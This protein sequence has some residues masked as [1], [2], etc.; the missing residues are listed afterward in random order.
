MKKI[1][2]PESRKQFYSKRKDSLV[3]KSNELGVVCDTYIALLMFSPTG[4]VTT[5][6]RGKSFEGI[7]INAINQP[8]ELNRQPTPNPDEEHL[9]QSLAQSK[10][11]RGMIEKIS[12]YEAHKEKLSELQKTLSEAKEKRRFYEPQVENINTVEEVDVYKEY[13]LGAMERVKRSKANQEFLKRNRNVMLS[14]VNA[15]DM[16]AACN[17]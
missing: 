8:D 1:E 9:M 17:N 14:S 5:Y 2:D 11:E 4:E 12:M 13:L 15:E 10:A 7:M 16:A 6:S 3:K